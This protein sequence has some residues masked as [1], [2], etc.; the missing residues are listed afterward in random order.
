MARMDGKIYQFEDY[1]LDVSEQRLQKN[2]EN[3]SLPPKVFEVLTALI[4]RHGQLVTYQELMDEVWHDT[5]VEETN[6][7][8]SI[9]TL[10]KTLP[11]R[12]I[13][14][15]PKRGYRF[16]S[17]VKSFTKEEFIKL[18]TG[19]FKKDDLMKSV[20]DSAEKN[21]TPIV[22]GKY[23]VIA[24]VACLMA[25]VGLAAY[26]FWQN[27]KEEKAAK[28]LKTVAVLPFSV[29]GEK[30][31]KTL[32]IQKGL[33]DSLVFNLG[34]IRALKITPTNEIQSYFGKE[35]DSLKVG[36]NLKADEVLTGTYR[37][38]ENLV[39]INFQLR[40]VS[41][42]EN[43]LTKSLTVKEENQVEI[44]NTVALQIA[45]QLDIRTARLID[46]QKIKSLDLSEETKRNYLTA[47]RIPRENEFDRWQ[48]STDLMKKVVDEN[49][50]W[51][52]SYAVYAESLVFTHGNALGC[53]DAPNFARKAIEIDPLVAE[54]YLV[55]G[56]CHQFKLEWKEAEENYRKAIELNPNLDRAYIE[57][58]TMLDFQRR[59]AEAEINLKKAIELEPFVPFYYVTLCE[60]YYFD[61]KYDEA[62][63][64]CY[65]SQKIEP[66]HWQTDKKLQ[67]IYVQQ[68]RYD[69]VEKLHYGNLTK[70]E[71]LKNPEA[72]ALL[73]GD[74]KKYWEVN[75]QTRFLNANKRFSPVAVAAFYAKLEDKE[76]TL[77]YLE[78]ATE[79]PEDMLY[80]AN[81]NP[82]FNFIRKEPRFI[83]LMKKVNLQP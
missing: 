48:E 3:I 83:E 67:W 12:F 71:K 4:K 69:E 7:R 80:R 9:H 17:E 79:K 27:E 29:I 58:G 34:K 19:N 30:P 66:N 74:I 56:F 28:H 72:K 77:E 23:A 43:L 50:N 5:F 2:G 10:R 76:K 44:E 26:Y 20:E 61:T 59:F 18:H 81:P 33:V 73:E 13:E 41:T 22:F 75:A 36:K 14:T 60:H 63:K 24:V 46:E 53:R 82:I 42:G 32:E 37:V 31:E 78:K 57:Y 49:P 40:Q 65:Q 1:L 6:L 62:L 70:E 52:L 38:E 25:G 45:R 8:Y 55:L 68:G 16:K 15:V 54:A 39:R 21:K 11:E 51:A 47:K 64:H 35:F